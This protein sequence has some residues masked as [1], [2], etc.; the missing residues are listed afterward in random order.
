MAL[1]V[2]GELD[3]GKDLLE[4]LYRRKYN[5]AGHTLAYGYGAGWFGEPDE[6]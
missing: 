2:D 6:T 4:K 5:R 3:K 1:I